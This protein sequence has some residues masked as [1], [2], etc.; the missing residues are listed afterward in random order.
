MDRAAPLMLDTCPC[1][2]GSAV[3]AKR[4]YVYEHGCG[5][6]HPDTEE[7]QCPQ[8]EGAGQILV[9]GPPIRPEDVEGEPI[10]LEDLEERA[11]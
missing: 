9:E 2:D 5:F 1:C 11:S 3:I 7:E 4:V 8:C 10:T 6:S